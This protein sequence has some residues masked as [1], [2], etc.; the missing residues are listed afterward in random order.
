MALQFSV[1]I[2]ALYHGKNFL[3]SVRAAVKAGARAV[4]FWSWEDKDFDGLV[5]LQKAEGLAVAA[6]CTRAV[7]M[8]DP[9]NRE[10]FVQGVRDSIAAAARVGCKTLITTVGDDTG[11]PRGTQ[12]RAIAEGL[13][14]CLPMLEESGTTLV[15]EPLNI[16]VDHIGYYLSASE[17]AFQLVDELGSD[18]VKVLFDIYHQQINEGDILRR[19]LP[20][21]SKIGHIHCAGSNGRHE[22][23]NGELNYGFLFEQ[24]EKAGYDRY[25]GL[26]YFPLRDPAEGLEKIF[27]N[28]GMQ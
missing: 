3:E 23:D 14:A 15:I 13:R 25:I 18:Y 11:A 26:E 24:L 22:L 10:A 20:N 17:E 7:Q 2:D 19:M 8:T 1:C 27:V 4:E 12:H 16:H 5:S 6:F 21:L 9:A 28:R